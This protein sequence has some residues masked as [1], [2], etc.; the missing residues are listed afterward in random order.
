MRWIFP[1]LYTILSAACIAASVC[2]TTAGPAA[3]TRASSAAS[4][5]NSASKGTPS[6][7][8][9]NNWLSIVSVAASSSAAVSGAAVCCRVLLLLPPLLSRARFLPL[10]PGAR[11]VGPVLLVASLAGCVGS[12]C[13]WLCCVVPSAAWLC[14][15]Y[16]LLDECQL[17]TVYPLL[18][19]R[20]GGEGGARLDVNCY[21]ESS[22][23]GQARQSGDEESHLN[24]RE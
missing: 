22:Q 21:D 15:P 19:T 14:Q 18:S 8:V 2:M 3:A 20:R 13:G 24:A 5:V 1:S 10:L 4:R 17:Y 11:S 7:S 23:I 6:S 9:P 12:G 16:L